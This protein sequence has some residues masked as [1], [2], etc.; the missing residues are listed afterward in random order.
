MS[1]LEHW[2]NSALG[3]WRSAH[4]LE[5]FFLD[6]EDAGPFLLLLL[7]RSLL[8]EKGV[9]RSENLQQLVFIDRGRVDFRNDADKLDVDFLNAGFLCLAVCQ[10]LSNMFSF[11]NYLDSCLSA[12]L[13]VKPFGNQDGA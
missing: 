1:E 4:G 10:F 2:N 6:P 12:Y 9:D 13:R 5:R 11:F 7:L 8:V 3:R